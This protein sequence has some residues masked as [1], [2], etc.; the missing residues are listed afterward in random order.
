MQSSKSVEYVTDSVS[1]CPK[2]HRFFVKILGLEVWMC[3]LCVEFVLAGSR[4]ET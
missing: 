1:A 4:S 3:V 2:M